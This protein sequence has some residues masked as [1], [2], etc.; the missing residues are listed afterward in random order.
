ME[1]EGIWHPEYGWIVDNH[2]KLFMELREDKGKKRREV[3]FREPVVQ[4]QLPFMQ[5]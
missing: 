3:E 1:L 2:D 4:L 5:L